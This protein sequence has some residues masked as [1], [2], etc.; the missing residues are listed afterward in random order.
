MKLEKHSC[1][2]IGK[3]RQRGAIR[4]E[5]GIETLSITAFVAESYSDTSGLYVPFSTVGMQIAR[6][7]MLF[8]ENDTQSP[9][10]PRFQGISARLQLY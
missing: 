6:K 2:K 5:I 3:R 4:G 7:D 9:I 8:V 10:P 1:L